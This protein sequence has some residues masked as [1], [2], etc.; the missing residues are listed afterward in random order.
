MLGFKGQYVCPIRL[1]SH[2]VVHCDPITLGGGGTIATVSSS[3]NDFG[4]NAGAGLMGY[5]SD[6][7]G[8][9]GDVR[10]LRT[11]QNNS[12]GAAISFDPG[13]FHFWR[14]SIGIVLR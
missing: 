10:Y 9:R 13:D 7:V 6:H 1:L 8:L 2:R 5:F 3:N 11:L 4:W 14:A 12:N